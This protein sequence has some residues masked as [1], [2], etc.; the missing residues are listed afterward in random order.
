[1][2]RKFLVSCQTYDRHEP[3]VEIGIDFAWID[4]CASGE[5]IN[6]FVNPTLSSSGLNLNRSS[7][8][9][10]TRTQKRSSSCCK[11]YIS[12]SPKQGERT[13]E[14]RGGAVF[15]Q[16]DSFLQTRDL[17][18]QSPIPGTERRDAAGLCESEASRGEVLP[19]RRKNNWY[20][21]GVREITISGFSPS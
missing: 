16:V 17:P 9:G 14:R 6:G 19:I 10:K 20:F 18:S 5:L 2:Y 15:K 21:S 11:E 4:A 12:Y 7:S 1:A 8:T 3:F 13:N